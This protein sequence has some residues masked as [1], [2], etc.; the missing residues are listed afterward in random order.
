MGKSKEKKARE[1]EILVR[2]LEKM[3]LDADDPDDLKV[4][5]LLTDIGADDEHVKA[6]AH[7]M[8]PIRKNKLVNKYLWKMQGGHDYRL[9]IMQTYQID[10]P[11]DE[12]FDKNIGNHYLLWHGTTK[13][14]VYA[15][16]KDGFRWAFASEN[17]MYE[18][19]IY[20]SNCV[21]KAAG[22]ISESPFKFAGGADDGSV[23]P[24]VRTGYLFLSE[25][26]LGK[27]YEYMDGEHDA[28]LL[29]NGADSSYG[30]GSNRPSSWRS[31]QESGS[32]FKVPVAPL[33]FVQKLRL[34]YDEY[35]VYRAT[36]I[37]HKFLVK[38]AVL[39]KY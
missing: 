24:N 22:Y 32:A 26:A 6:I 33:K 39:P 15:I 30:K 12:N 23:R 11:R 18:N 3:G 34:H 7:M 20:F 13:N 1:W 28:K 2:S 27:M 37:R 25:V 17:A 36:Q 38:V 19:G 4:R 21:T 8:T 31:V 35:V 5:N 29:L 10:S 9:Q 16:L 14:N